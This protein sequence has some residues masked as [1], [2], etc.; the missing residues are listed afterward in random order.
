MSI[1]FSPKEALA[2]IAKS[3]VLSS[4]TSIGIPPEQ[5]ELFGGVLE[6]TIKGF[7]YRY[8][9][10]STYK[11]LND[12]IRRAIDEVILQNPDYEIPRDC[13]DSLMRVFSFDNAINYL[14]SSDPGHELNNAI[15]GACSQSMNCE[16][17]TL[18]LAHMAENLL[19]QICR[20]I[21]S[22]HELSGLFTMVLTEEISKKLDTII[23]LVNTKTFANCTGIDTP[24]H[25]ANRSVESAQKYDGYFRSYLFSEK[26]SPD[27]L[28]LCDVYVDPCISNSAGTEY[29]N[30]EALF[31]TFQNGEVL[32]LEGEAGS[33]KSS[34]L[35]RI[36]DKYLKKEIF[37]GRTLFF[38]QG[39]EIRHSK[40]MPMDDL[41]NALKLQCA[42]SLDC[43]IVFLDAYDEISFAAASS[44]NNQ[45]YLGK[46]LQGCEGF[47]LIIT[48]RANYIKTFNGPRFQ[49]KGFNPEQRS[50]FLKKYNAHRNAENKLSK[51]Y[52]DSLTHED[53]FYEDGIYE[54]LSIPMLL[55][56]IAV[57]KV[58]IS[59]IIDKFDLFELVFFQEGQGTMISRGND[60]KVI[61]KK[62]WSDSYSLALSISK[63]MFFN[64]DSF[65]SEDNIRSSID[66]MDTSKGIK[67]ILKNRF[68]IEIFLTSSDSSI[69]TFVHRSIFEYF[70]A[71]GICA[72]L[73]D[74][75]TRY[76]HKDIELSDVIAAV[77]NIFPADYYNESVFFYVMYAI[78]RGYVIDTLAS[79]EKLLCVEAMFHK[80]LASQLCNS[81][82]STIPYIV[83]LKNL[84]LWVFNS[85][86]VIFGLH[87]IDGDSHWVQIDQSILQYIL[88]I[89]EPEETLFISHCNLRKI[90]FYK[91]DLG[92]VFFINNDLTGAFFKDTNCQQI[93]FVGQDFQNASF[94]SADFWRGDF[95]GCSF[96]NSD[97][98][99]TDFREA[100]LCEASFRN[101]DLRCGHFS[102]A[103]LS[104]ADFAGA[105]I[106][107][108]DFENAIYNE[109]AFMNAIIHDYETD[110]PNEDIIEIEVP[111]Q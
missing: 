34:L 72:E 6:G 43:S 18:P 40:G 83:R 87:E 19:Q 52:I 104:G 74:I 15:Q 57:N 62:I 28:R 85:F 56:M 97:L 71:K 12:T 77:N 3:I 73:K 14:R 29:S 98:R 60:Q 95:S 86:S 94:H 70:A 4:A 82:S 47:T 9:E 76:I 8:G 33:G 106:Y 44:E 39:K 21:Y 27:P 93:V 1:S 37:Q 79:K 17:S 13:V 107:L 49:L 41:L 80:L 110:D 84:F 32:L 58:D 59:T 75:I 5:A 99:Y 51:E 61:S 10:K 26:E 7:G 105:H 53:S 103:N 23:S 30:F 65:I 101:S 91:F 89:K 2:F 64:N 11:Q 90:S 111:A 24:E 100:N 88:R 109:D 48:V 63:S 96:N 45:E 38:V 108:E 81:G 36:A 92:S 67:D 20:E 16:V 25:I 35:M 78:N 42:E 55:Y 66:D 31:S 102:N 54:L 46:L 68:G 50:C 69:Y 22:N